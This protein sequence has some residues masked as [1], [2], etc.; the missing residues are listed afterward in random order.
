M[1]LLF[2]CAGMGIV[3]GMT[4]QMREAD[5]IQGGE[6]A[7]ANIA[8]ITPTD[9]YG[10]GN[11]SSSFSF[12]IAYSFEFEGRTFRGTRFRVGSHS[13]SKRLRR[14]KLIADLQA[15]STHTAYFEATKPDRAV[16]D[17]SIATDRV[18]LTVFG[19]LFAFVGLGLFSVV[20]RKMFYDPALPIRTRTTEHGYLIRDAFTRRIYIAAIAA[21]AGIAS[22]ALAAWVATTGGQ[23]RS[24]DISIALAVGVG[25]S[26]LAAIAASRF[27]RS[28][29]GDVEILPRESA[30]LIHPRFGRS[31][32]TRIAMEDIKDIFVEVAGIHMYHPSIAIA[33]KTGTGRSKAITLKQFPHDRADAKELVGWLRDQVALPEKD[34]MPKE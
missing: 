18:I 8:S 11:R 33:S 2:T 4:Y 12:E 28:G 29:A 32:P 22:L 9:D 1:G 13:T 14:D 30:I 7:P 10:G 19:G 5:R 23:I 24:M 31:G 20:G 3:W 21:P 27:C 25:A 15:S 6:K 16:L 17:P 26:A 34:F